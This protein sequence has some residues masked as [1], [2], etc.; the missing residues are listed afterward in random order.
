MNVMLEWS[1]VAITLYTALALAMPAQALAS[2][3]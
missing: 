2:L 1:A 3:I